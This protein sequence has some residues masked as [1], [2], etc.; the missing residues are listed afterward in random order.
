MHSGKEVNSFNKYAQIMKIMIVM[1]LKTHG[2]TLGARQ[3]AIA[4]KGISS[5]GHQ[6]VV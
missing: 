2:K 6:K 5:S 4:I 1:A 3:R